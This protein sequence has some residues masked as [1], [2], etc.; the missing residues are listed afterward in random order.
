MIV[1]DPPRPV[2]VF[3][4]TLMV[5][6]HDGIGADSIKG[7]LEN[8]RFSNHCMSPTV[9]ESESREVPWTDSHPLNFSTKQTK[10]FR[11]LFKE[12]A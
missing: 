5:I 10:A 1:P 4:V 8:T 11:D 3:K 7:E 9:V 6:D 2:Q 12:G